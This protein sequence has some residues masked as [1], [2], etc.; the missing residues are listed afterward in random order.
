MKVVVAGGGTGGHVTPGL[1]VARRLIDDHGATVRFVGSSGGFEARMVPE[2]G[3]EFH[4]I[5]AAPLYREL[6]FRAAR[7]PFVAARSVRRARTLV[8]GA[9]VV[10]GVGGYASVPTGVAARR[11]RIPLVLHEQNAIPSL[12]NRVLAR[13]ASAIGS[14][15]ATA[16]SRFPP[17]VRVEHTGNPVRS[18]ILAVATRRAELAAEAREAFRLEPDRGTVLVTGGSQ[19]AL[20]LDRVVAEAL[21]AL[22]SQPLQ[23]IVLTGRDHVAVVADAVE[24]GPAPLVHVAPF[25]DR[26][27]LAYAVA[28][29]VVA[30]AG[31]ATV[32]EI[33]VCG[34]PCVLVPYPHAT[35]NHQEANARELVAVGGA[36]MILDRALSSDRLLTCILGVMNDDGKRRSMARAMRS[37]ARPDAD[38][39]LADLVAAVAP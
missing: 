30:R 15:F 10:I 38:V 1:A 5:E 24:R 21:P 4:G 34:L 18:A 33:A 35:A 36:R 13:W 17:A 32:T 23:L 25:L 9:D 14:T 22:A 26:I 39:R 12:S 29:V 8:R 7:A 28:D 2:A 3:I 6:S 20:H 37:W 31:A 16:A 27:E 11:E 19:G